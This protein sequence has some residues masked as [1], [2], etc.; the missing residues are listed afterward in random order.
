MNIQNFIRNSIFLLSFHMVQGSSVNPFIHIP[1][2]TASPKSSTKLSSNTPRHKK[3]V[4]TSTQI[5]SKQGST[6][7]QQA[8][9]TYSQMIFVPTIPTTSSF[10]EI[11][12]TMYASTDLPES[13]LQE[14]LQVYF[15][16]E[17][18]AKLEKI[19]HD[20]TYSSL[21]TKYASLLSP[22]EK[23]I[24]FI[25][26]GMDLAA[27]NTWQNIKITQQDILKSD[28]WQ[29]FLKATIA[30]IFIHDGNFL[31]VIHEVESQIFNYIPSMET[32]YYNSD[33][34]GLRNLAEGT[35]LKLLLNGLVQS[36]HVAQCTDWAKL[37]ST[38]LQ[39]ASTA[40]QATDFYNY[41]HNISLWMQQNTQGA[42]VAQK[43]VVLQSPTKEQVFCYAM[44][45]AA[46][47]DLYTAL[48]NSNDLENFI[49]QASSSSLL[50]NIFEYT[51]D[52]YVYLD[53]F[54]M[55]QANL[56]TQIE[57]TNPKSTKSNSVSVQSL[58]DASD[59]KKRKKYYK[60]ED[61]V[62]VQN[63]TIPAHASLV[64][65]AGA[66]NPFLLE[67]DYIPEQTTSDFH[68]VTSAA[69]FFD[70]A[71]QE[72]KSGI[73]NFGEN[74]LTTLKNLGGNLENDFI[75]AGYAIRDGII[76]KG[77]AIRDI[78]TSTGEAIG[79]LGATVI[80]DIAHDP[81]LQKTGHNLTQQAVS[82]MAQAGTELNNAIDDFFTAIKD[83]CIAPEADIAGA[84]T[85]ILT[86]D[87]SM[88][89][90]VTTMINQVVDSVYD[91]VETYAHLVVN[92]WTGVAIDAIVITTD[93]ADA[94]VKSVAA[95]N[96]N[97]RDGV[98]DAWTQ[99]GNDMG[100]A[101][102]GGI[103]GLI[104]GTKEM[105]AAIMQVMTALTSAIT[106]IIIDVSKE[107]TFMFEALATGNI[108]A[109][110]AEENSV[111][112]YLDDHRQTINMVSG[113]ILAIAIDV[114]VTVATG[115]AGT[116][117]AVA[118]TEGMMT[119]ADIAVATAE[120]GAEIAATAAADAATTAAD[121][122][123][124]SASIA[125]NTA[126][127]ATTTIARNTASVT[128]NIGTTAAESTGEN[129]AQATAENLSTITRTTT[130]IGR[131]TTQTTAET[132]V[133]SIIPTTG[134]I[135]RTA[136][137]TARTTAVDTGKA[138][139]QATSSAI[140][141]T[142]SNAA[143]SAA[144]TAK[145]AG[146]TAKNTKSAADLTKETALATRTTANN[147]KTAASAARDSADAAKETATTARATASSSRSAANKA[148]QAASQAEAEGAGNAGELRAAANQADQ[149]ATK[150]ENIAS[151]ADDAAS[152]AER[153]AKDAEDAASKAE[154]IATKAEQAAI[155]A[156]GKFSRGWT[157]VAFSEV[158]NAAFNI[159]GAIGSSYQ[160]EMTAEQEIT[161]EEGVKNIA[162]YALDTALNSSMQQHAMIKETEKK[163]NANIANQQLGLL[164]LKDFVNNVMVNATYQ[165]EAV[166]LGQEYIE[167]LTPQPYDTSNPSN[168]YYP[169]DIGST[170]GLITAVNS[171][172]PQLG[173]YT[174][175][176]GRPQFPYAQEIAQAPLI[177][178]SQAGQQQATNLD[179]SAKTQSIT[180][181]WFNQRVMIP[182]SS[183][184]ATDPLQVEVQF[185]KLYSLETT[186]YTGLY[187]GGTFED[188][189]SKNYITSLET[190]G[191]ANLNVAHLAKMFVLI[192][193]ANGT[194][195]IGLY[196]KDGLGTIKDPSGA[197]W[198]IYEPLDKAFTSGWPIYDMKAKLQGNQ[199]TLTLSRTDNPKLAPWQK[200]V[201]VSPTDQRMLGIITSGT[202]IEFNI[203]QPNFSIKQAPIR[204]SG[205]STPITIAE[206]DREIQSLRKW[207]QL[208]NPKFGS[209]RLQALNKF[210]CMNGKYV[211]TTTDT[212]ILDSNNKPLTDY[213]I[214][215]NNDASGI[216][217]VGLNPYD[218]NTNTKNLALISLGSGNVYDANGK[219]IGVQQKVWDSYNKIHGPFATQIVEAISSMQNACLSALL[220]P[221][222]GIFKLEAADN[223]LISQGLYVY[224]TTQTLTQGDQKNPIV[225][226]LIT[227][228]ISN[229][230]DFSGNPLTT[231]GDSF[232]APPSSATE[233][234]LSLV[235]GNLYL[236]SSLTF[237]NNGYDSLNL[238]QNSYQKLPT[239]ITTMIANSLKAYT[240]ATTAKPSSTKNQSKQQT[241]PATKQAL[242]T[243]PKAII[244]G[245]IHDANIANSIPASG[246]IS[247]NDLVTTPQVKTQ[248][249]TKPATASIML[250]QQV[251]SAGIAFSIDLMGEASDNTST[252][253]SSD[254]AS[255]KTPTTSAQAPTKSIKKTSSINSTTENPAQTPTAN[256]NSH[257]ETNPI[258]SQKQPATKTKPS[259]TSQSTQTVATNPFAQKSTSKVSSTSQKA[260][261]QNI[262][263]TTPALQQS[264]TATT[265]NPFATLSKPTATQTT[266]TTTKQAIKKTASSPKKPT[267]P[268]SSSSQ[269]AQAVGT[270]NNTQITENSNPSSVV[271]GQ[272]M[273]TYTGGISFNI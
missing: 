107:A 193:L 65:P 115:G 26:Q 152:K 187:L 81:N 209:F 248:T 235:T 90:D 157:H 11:L 27:D 101:I 50:P 154:S 172:Y 40:F 188:Y 262:T 89:L 175:T 82:D 80:G 242:S 120:T 20:T 178:D 61:L 138:T 45:K 36:K 272:T 23:D 195:N 165:S 102:L 125:A 74:A 67:L 204:T 263:T 192:N 8:P 221:I 33:F 59:K 1:Q 212:S 16:L 38:Q 142:V 208:L 228:T 161:Q 224:T 83:G 190:T 29:Y 269:P 257:K 173:L 91:V 261:S 160:D 153:G 149:A 70:Q 10:S 12:Q 201:T 186:T 98:G 148:D 210:A 267:T 163:L 130:A 232:G 86:E 128:K 144:N 177:I 15:V 2:T 117:E 135:G 55:I 111:G 206:T 231:I 99:L 249:S 53:D 46:Q 168:T 174:T 266:T 220:K 7:N 254:S 118:L 14:I 66:T 60:T 42:V 245:S 76:Q 229:T 24:P 127:T 68:Y 226:Y 58:Q 51:L 106:T 72:F 30:D 109:A 133:D 132:S 78:F 151:K 273:K 141:D 122:A 35:R 137:S 13:T 205:S 71:G 124:A 100:M 21:Q 123:E 162:S 167:L 202:A 270:K 265:T 230:T 93:I 199:L 92:G 96:P 183:Q 52:E 255:I 19:Q 3:A 5:F 75:S 158:F 110:K 207:S 164:M 44:I 84:I 196:E 214:F 203:L 197:S 31:Q 241:L 182:L 129:I 264:E 34:L 256:P 227:S 136:T 54:F 126:R 6:T 43:K 189:R 171:L 233:G 238:Y 170:W 169:A 198:I 57:E 166:G 260:T 39:T 41:S 140:E 79:G 271:T 179:G 143:E 176:L 32:S 88:G 236:P 62:K 191:M 253:T 184:K 139:S 105:F 243:S 180:Q 246:G 18:F 239:N 116:A 131:N 156:A 56:A 185:R 25:S 218:K 85:A 225:D 17:Y 64:N 22:S 94:I 108:Q 155:K 234:L 159:L 222:V 252:E 244:G 112:T 259:S 194:T 47:N 104:T 150:A 134:N 223:D 121:A 250:Q 69:D 219:I 95:M 114:A 213:M 240:A 77:Y 258:D 97:N 4:K 145:T 211:Y 9:A 200:T 217:N 247:F 103:Q 119:G 49:T 37:S 215:A 48:A 181:L 63:T 237:V 146:N 28:M 251:A 147:A 216:N 113:I 268:T 87:Q 73:I